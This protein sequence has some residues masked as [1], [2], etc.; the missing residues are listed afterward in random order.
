ME[1]T[2]QDSESNSHSMELTNDLSK[3]AKLG[4]YL[5][6]H[7]RYGIGSAKMISEMTD[8]SK[9]QTRYEERPVTYVETTV[10]ISI[11]FYEQY[12]EKGKFAIQIMAPNEF[13]TG[14]DH[15]EVHES[16]GI[17]ISPE[18][19]KGLEDQIKK[20]LPDMS[21]KVVEEKRESEN[22][23][24]SSYRV[25]L[26]NG[27][28]SVYLSLHAAWGCPTPDVYQIKFLMD[29]DDTKPLS[30]ESA[31]CVD[32]ATKVFEVLSDEKPNSFF[33]NPNYETQIKILNDERIKLIDDD[34]AEPDYAQKFPY[35]D[36]A[37]YDFKSQPFLNESE[38]KVYT[39]SLSRALKEQGV[40]LNEPVVRLHYAEIVGTERDG[41]QGYDLLTANATQVFGEKTYNLKTSIGSTHSHIIE[42]RDKRFYKGAKYTESKMVL[43]EFM[44]DPRGLILETMSGKKYAVW[45]LMRAYGF[46]NTAGMHGVKSDKEIFDPEMLKNMEERY[47]MTIV[48]G[49][50]SEHIL[51]S[52]I[53]DSIIDR[54]AVEWF[55][56]QEKNKGSGHDLLRAKILMKSKVSPDD[57]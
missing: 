27:A 26:D 34:S 6:V 5:N 1:Y 47:N 40:E 7:Y 28:N 20:V 31:Y 12:E 23:K 10:P 3:L 19:I 35:E 52:T 22:Y 15:K 16:K 11:Y 24:N 50:Q 43:R 25:L 37:N 17:V 2:L 54:A 32:T 30:E 51:E 18:K 42:T 9:V 29:I 14:E 21:V 44:E 36:I 8:Y 46:I 39:M 49:K 13:S 33:V 41:K 55:E 38:A 57:E 56:K 45:G 4:S 53:V 48:H